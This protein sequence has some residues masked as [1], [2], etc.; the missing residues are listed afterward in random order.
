MCEVERIMNSRP[1]TTVSND[2]NDNEPL[3]P[4]Q[5]QYLADIFWERWSR[6][7]LPLMQLTAYTKVGTP[8]KEFGCW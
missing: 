6:E 2:P 7:Y 3:T 1:I 4:R 5:V 8:K